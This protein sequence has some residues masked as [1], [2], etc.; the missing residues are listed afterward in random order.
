MDLRLH[1]RLSPLGLT[2][3]LLLALAGCQTLAGSGEGKSQ[4]VEHRA[5]LGEERAAIERAAVQGD[6]TS[7]RTQITAIRTRLATIESQ[8]SAMNMIDRQHLAIQ[9][10][11]ARRIMAEAERW[12]DAGDAESVRTEVDRLG[13]TLIEIDTI[14]DRTIRGSKPEESAT[15]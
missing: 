3:A 8:S 10:A 15:G 7:I 1:R 2:A 14:L 13:G 6:L 4:F 9:G 12:M 11:T 5:K